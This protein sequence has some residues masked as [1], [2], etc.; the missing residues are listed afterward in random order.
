MTG[1]L[2]TT[3]GVCISMYFLVIWNKHVLYPAVHV[4]CHFVHVTIIW[5]LP[6]PYPRRSIVAAVRAI[7]PW[8]AMRLYLCTVLAKG[9]LIIY[10]SV[11]IHREKTGVWCCQWMSSNR[12]KRCFSPLLFHN[13]LRDLVA[14]YFVLR[15]CRVQFRSTY[16]L[17]FCVFILPVY[18]TDWVKYYIQF[19][20]KN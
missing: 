12:F 19:L 8:L 6:T 13:V 11:L 10:Y 2:L 16:L 18:F 20:I 7:Q 9:R 15:W 14:D 17:V 5:P 4:G 3:L 1:D